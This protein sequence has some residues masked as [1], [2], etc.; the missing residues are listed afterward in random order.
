MAHINDRPFGIE[1]EFSTSVNDMKKII[2]PII[3]KVYGDRSKLR[4]SHSHCSTF[5]ND[6]WHLKS[7]PSSESELCSPISTGADLPHICK[8]IKE[9]GKSRAKVTRNDSFHLHIW[10]GDIDI[11]Q[12]VASW[13]KYESVIKKCFPEHRWVGGSY[14][15]PVLKYKGRSKNIATFH[16]G[17]IVNNEKHKILNIG[18]Y[19]YRKTVE[20]RISEGTTDPDHVYCWTKACLSFMNGMKSSDVVRMLCE[21]VNNETI[22]DFVRRFIREQRVEKWLKMRFSHGIKGDRT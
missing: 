10:S 20:I 8:V 22:H 3:D 2:I 9:L 17:A 14:N 21:N 4:V 6:Y 19:K 11:N 1:L 18:H 7:E 16:Q 15:Q 5:K 13:L 12:L